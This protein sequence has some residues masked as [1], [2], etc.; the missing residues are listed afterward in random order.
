M[1]YYQHYENLKDSLVPQ[2]TLVVQ[3]IDTCLYPIK[4]N[5]TNIP[6]ISPNT[7]IQ[8]HNLIGLSGTARHPGGA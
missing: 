7:H 5:Q 1:T 3:I 4:S 6:N 2:G 8:T